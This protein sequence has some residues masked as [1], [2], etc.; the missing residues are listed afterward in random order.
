MTI[1]LRPG[2]TVMF[3]GDSITDC[4]RLES[5]DGLGFG[6]PLRIAGEWGLQHPDR[7][8]TWLNTGIAGHKVMDLEARWQADVLDARPDVVSILVGVNDMGWHTYDPDGY[9]IPAEDYAAGYDR[10]LAPLAEAGTELILIEPF[11]LPIRVL[12]QVVDTHVGETERKEWR[13]DLDPKIQA[14]HELARKYG[15]HLLA[16]DDMFA[17]LAVTTGPEYWAA[18]G[19]HPT[20]AGHAALAAAWLRLVA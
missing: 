1:T 10:L 15:A 3:T 16:A 20:P 17:E 12:I 9:V 8:V 6:Y 4:Q 13:A 19:V 7:A 2:T 18:D 11:L 14:V 5:E